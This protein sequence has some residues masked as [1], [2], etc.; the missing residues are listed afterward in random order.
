MNFMT[1]VKLIFVAFIAALFLSCSDDSSTNNNDDDN[2][3]NN[4]S[5]DV[6]AT[7]RVISGK[8]QIR[9][10]DGFE[11][12]Y[13]D[14]T[15]GAADI[16]LYFGVNSPEL[17]VGEGTIDA[18]G[19]FEL[20]LPATVKEEYL[21][22]ASFAFAGFDYSP[23]DLRINIV[24][25]QAYVEYEED[26][27]MQERLIDCIIPIESA[28]TYYSNK[29]YF[30]F[31]SDSGHIKGFE[32]NGREI[33]KEFDKGWNMSNYDYINNTRTISEQ[34]PNDAIYYCY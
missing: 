1:Y 12:I 9:K 31:F 3:N 32:S 19:N 6:T 17:K 5:G 23:D 7:E 2:N 13:T 25:L 28:D 24:P 8:L 16:N 10:A 20:T 11:Y 29:F 21:V 30:E 18:A 33:D 14:W 26:G 34:K 15:R 4:D 27:E 22:I